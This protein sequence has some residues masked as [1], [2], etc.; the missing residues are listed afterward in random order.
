MSG[1][2]GFTGTTKRR[3]LFSHKID[4]ELAGAPP[5]IFFFPVAV[6][7]GNMRVPS[8]YILR[9]ILPRGGRPE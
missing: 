2:S 6:L 1:A 9:Q 5:A 4:A 8:E 3:C 7:G